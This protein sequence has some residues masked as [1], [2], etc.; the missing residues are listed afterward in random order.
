MTCATTFALLMCLSADVAKD[1]PPG[2]TRV[3]V[4]TV[5]NNLPESFFEYIL[6]PGR[7]VPGTLWDTEQHVG[8][9]TITY[10]ITPPSKWN[11]VEGIDYVDVKHDSVE[12][13]I[14]IRSEGC[15]ITSSLISSPTAQD[16]P[17]VIQL[18]RVESIV[19]RVVGPDGE[20]LAN[21]P[22]L[23]GS[24][25]VKVG[26]WDLAGLAACTT[27]GDG[28]FLLS[29]YPSKFPFMITTYNSKNACGYLYIDNFD[30]AKIHEIRLCE[31]ASLAG[32]VVLS[33]G[34]IKLA[35]VWIDL[36]TSRG[37]RYG[38][39][40]ADVNRETGEFLVGNLPPGEVSLSVGGVSPSYFLWEKEF[41]QKVMA[42]L[43]CGKAKELEIPVDT[44]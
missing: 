4:Q 38:T 5:E 22:I 35:S 1:V 19:G 40:I 32:T 28:R 25:P 15:E 8:P 2:N 27:D 37:E 13:T 6:K 30:R 16:G 7:L 34:S 43:E 9:D 18:K 44:R 23:L 17:T 10:D 31:P 3:Y 36:L 42:Q 21:S 20:G 29:A 26:G 33:H 39:Y 41:S 24:L 12:Q 14:F 11:K